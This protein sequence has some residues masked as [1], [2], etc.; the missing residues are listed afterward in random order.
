LLLTD[1]SDK[2]LKKEPDLDHVAKPMQISSRVAEANSLNYLQVS[3]E[4]MITLP[5]AGAIWKIR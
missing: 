1:K 4:N 5:R 2:P 3:P